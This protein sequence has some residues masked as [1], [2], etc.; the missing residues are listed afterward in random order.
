MYDFNR[1]VERKGTESKKHDDFPF[2]DVPEEYYPLWIADMDYETAPEIVAALEERM[3][4]KVFGY[5]VQEERYYEAIIGWHRNRYCVTNLKRE[6]ICYQN[7][8]LAGIC[9]AVDLYTSEGEAIIIQTPAY[10]GFTAILRNMNRNIIQNPM[11]ED[12]GYYEIDFKHFEESIVEHKVKI[13]IHCNPHNPTGRIWTVEENQKLVEICQRHEVLILSD[14]IWSDMI[15]NT[16]RKHT[17]LVVAVPDAKETTISYYSPSKGFN[18]AGMWSAYSVC[19]NQEMAAQL[20]RK[21]NYLHANAGGVLAIETTIAAYE[22]GCGWLE[23][24]IAYTSAN[25]DYILAFLEEKLPKIKCRKPDATYLMWLDFTEVGITHLELLDRLY[26]QAGVLCNSGE[27][28]LTGGSLHV[29]LNPTASRSIIEK[30]MH[31]L[32]YAFADIAK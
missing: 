29:R 7:G 14:E 27:D 2:I 25:M 1:V 31:A 6:H 24:C 19:Y 10:V 26:C 11:I 15:M 5:F 32:E 22:S 18:L 16:N 23:E 9:H 4:H 8:V 12:S 3:K 30:A 21:S 13:F 20:E 17:P 28:F